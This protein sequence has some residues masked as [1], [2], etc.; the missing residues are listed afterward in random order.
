MMI[1]YRINIIRWGSIGRFR[2]MENMTSLG[3]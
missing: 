1:L 2:A 3:M